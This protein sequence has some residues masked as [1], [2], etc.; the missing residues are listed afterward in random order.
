[1]RIFK[2]R[3]TW[4]NAELA[5]IKVSILSA[6]VVAGTCFH[7]FFYPSLPYLCFLFV[8]STVWGVWLW[9][10]KMKQK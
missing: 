10:S 8:I 4:T 7:D 9:V 6:G 2:I 3:T 5:I 1:M